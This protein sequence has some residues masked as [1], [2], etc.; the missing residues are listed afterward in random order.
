MAYITSIER[1][2]IAEATQKYI[3]QILTIRF[4]NVPIE[5][6]EKLNKLYD[7]ELLNELL[8]KAVAIGS[9]S[10]FGQQL[11]HEDTNIDNDTSR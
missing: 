7:I 5:L 6:V 11:S 8:E 1:I 4:K 2:G 10:E 9:I 3:A